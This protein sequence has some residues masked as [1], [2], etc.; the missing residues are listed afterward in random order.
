MNTEVRS[1]KLHSQFIREDSILDRMKSIELDDLI[2]Q[3]LTQEQ[4]EEENKQQIETYLMTPIKEFRSRCKALSERLEFWSRQPASSFSLECMQQLRNGT[5]MMVVLDDS[6]QQI[7][8]NEPK[9]LTFKFVH[10]CCDHQNIQCKSPAQG[11]ELIRPDQGDVNLPLLS[12]CKKAMQIQLLDC[13]GNLVQR[14][15]QVLIWLTQQ[16]LVHEHRISRG[17]KTLQEVQRCVVAHEVC[18]RCKGQW[19]Q[20]N[21]VCTNKQCVNDK[22]YLL[23]SNERVPGWCS[24]AINLEMKDG[25]VDLSPIRLT[26]VGERSKSK[27]LKQNSD[28]QLVATMNTQTVIICGISEPF[29]TIALRTKKFRNKQQKH[30]IKQEVVG[31][32][33]N[34][35]HPPSP[36]R[37]RRIGSPKSVLGEQHTFAPRLEPSPFTHGFGPN[38]FAQLSQPDMIR[39][40]KQ[41]GNAQPQQVQRDD[42][43]RMW[44]VQENVQVERI[45]L[46]NNPETEEKPQTLSSPSHVNVL[47]QQQ[48]HWEQQDQ[49]QRCLPLAEAERRW[50]SFEQCMFLIRSNS[51][52]VN[53]PSSVFQNGNNIQVDL[54]SG[55]LKEE[56][57]PIE[58][59]VANLDN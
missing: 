57:R 1:Q 27:Q 3:M 46:Q 45:P 43:V 24:Y 38:I 29:R 7:R 44:Q 56:G 32:I 42:A 13:E 16:N 36:K 2:D 48:Q 4:C 52:N 47:E 35:S 28:F 49:Q 12:R 15:G 8:L 55:G 6:L 11:W 51:L 58:S 21:T 31:L 19:S 14:D 30:L 54:F 53:V 33:P 50:S 5:Q 59:A 26:L 22:P 10:D 34:D 23:L 9:G 37:Q 25:V 41:T 18:D 17:V 39:Q 20:Q 40:K